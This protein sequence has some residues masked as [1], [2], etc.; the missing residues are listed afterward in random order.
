MLILYNVSPDLGHV[1]SRLE[2]ELIN[3]QTDAKLSLNISLKELGFVSY[4]FTNKSS[5]HDLSVNCTLIDL[6]L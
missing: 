5:N 6:N 4:I 1:S 2:E 3:L